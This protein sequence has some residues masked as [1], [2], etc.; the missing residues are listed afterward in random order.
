MDQ[1]KVINMVSRFLDFYQK[2]TEAELVEEERFQLWQEEVNFAALP[3]GES[4]E[5]RARQLLKDAWERYAT[6]ID[7]LKQWEPNEQQIHATV[8]QVKQLLGYEAPLDFV[9]IYFVGGFDNNP[10]VAPYDDERLALCLPVENGEDAIYLVH[11]LTHI[12]HS[13]TAQLTAN[14][15]RSIASLV[16]QEGL[17]MQVSKRLIPKRADE[18]YTEYTAGWLQS[19]HAHRESILKGIMPFLSQETNEVVEQFTFGK[20]TTGHEREAYYVGWEVV[21][22]L[23][24]EGVSFRD[25]AALREEDL[26]QSVE[27]VILSLLA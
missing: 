13:H 1:I 27:E 24:A 17:A 15:E 5:M 6:E 9:V 22:A 26:P 14:W 4:R 3:P 2:A 23:L 7:H 19:C 21:G 11:E 10:F 16:I 8:S 12:V 18:A 20:G 25:I